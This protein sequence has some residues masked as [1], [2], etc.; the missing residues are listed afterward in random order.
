MYNCLLIVFIIKADILHILQAGPSLSI[1][2]FKSFISIKE[3][4]GEF[5]TFNRYFFG[6]HD[7][8]FLKKPAPKCG[9]LPSC[10]TSPVIV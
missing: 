7:L 8:C 2:S 5:L 1:T 9:R 4:H 6:G 3:C 10:L